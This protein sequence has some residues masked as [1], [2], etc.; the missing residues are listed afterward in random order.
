MFVTKLLQKTVDN[1]VDC[2]DEWFS[3]EKD[4]CRMM[5]DKM[6]GLCSLNPAAKSD[7][8][9]RNKGFRNGNRSDNRHDTA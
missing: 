8:A 9:R 6:H 4:R 5:Q 7:K 1:P 2:V 3:R